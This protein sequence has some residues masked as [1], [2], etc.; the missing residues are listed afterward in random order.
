MIRYQRQSFSVWL[1]EVLCLGLVYLLT[2]SSGIAQTTQLAVGQ[3]LERELAGGQSH[4]YQLTLEGG[5]FF[6]G[7]V[8]QKG[9]DV[10]VSIVSPDGKTTLEV[11]SPNGA[12]GTESFSVVSA[13]AGSYQIIVRAIEKGALPGRYEIKLTDLRAASKDEAALFAGQQIYADAQ[14]LGAKRTAIPMREAQ[15][16]YR[17]ALELFQAV[18][19]H[20][21]QAQSYREIGLLWRLLGDHEQALEAYRQALP[22]FRAAGNKTAEAR[23]LNNLG[24]TYSDLGNPT[25]AVSHL[26]QAIQQLRALND[27]VEVGVAW[28]NLGKVYRRFSNFPR[29]LECHTA[30]LEIFQKLKRPASET[31]TLGNLGSLYNLLGDRERAV[32]FHQQALALSRTHKNQQA[33]AFNLNS[34]GGLYR[35]LDQPEQ[36]RHFTEQGLALNRKVGNKNG[37]ATALVYLG[38]L[39]FAQGEREAGLELMAQGVTIGRNLKNSISIAI[40]LGDLGYFL[41]EAGRSDEAIPHLL[42]SLTLARQTGQS[43]NERLALHYLAL[44]ER[45]RGRFTEARAYLDQSIAIVER[46]RQDVYSLPQRAAIVSSKQGFYSDS[47]DLY[48]RQHQQAPQSGFDALALAGNEQALA[49]SLLD[50]LSESRLELRMGVDSSLLA[51]EGQLQLAFSNKAA[52]RDR[53]KNDQA[54]T[55]RL[56]ELTQQL[57]ALNAEIETTQAT[58]RR[59]SPRF[60]ALVQT[61]PASLKEIQ[62]LLDADTL[63]LEYALG[64]RRSHLLVV[65]ANELQSY[66]LPKYGAIAAAARQAYRELTNAPAPV[67]PGSSKTLAALSQLLLSPIRAKLQREWKGKRLLVVA[68]YELQ[69]IPFA[70]LPIDTDHQIPLLTN[71]EIINLPSASVLAVLRKQ[72]AGRAVA[73]L[74]VAVL[75]DPVFSESDARVKS[76]LAKQSGAVSKEPEKDASLTASLQRAVRSVTGEDRAGLQRL[77]FTRYEAEAIAAL[78]PAGSVLKALDFQASRATA[79]SDKLANYRIIHFATHGLLDSAHPELSG[80]ALSLVDENGKPQDGYLRLNEIFNLK[81]NAD[82][83]VLSACQTGLGKEV[84]GE[85]LIGLT[86]GFMYAGAP[87]VVASL[88]QVNDAAT[89]ELMK[90]FY[91]GM[92][93]EKLRPAAALRQAQLELMKKPAW[94]APYYWGAFVLQG[95]WK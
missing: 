70:T 16:K 27:E 9:I 23:M 95:E 56:A 17:Q 77:A 11:D 12:Q 87:R 76:A 67:T 59:A 91:R 58:I 44:A 69:Y 79:L 31:I 2:V 35:L 75:G 38:K 18:D 65:T 20:Q 63:L 26:E 64:S 37:E 7:I 39:L 48:L 6:R 28:D 25:E 46:N 49:R 71:H 33:E 42:E 72:F 50:L 53:L 43:S 14:T 51:R 80:L 22:L 34:L 52:L 41:N 15:A 61:Q 83:V 8:E 74:T 78:V 84:K 30:A 92:L 62:S 5:Q 68:P 85:G 4:A 45:D 32:Q 54:A 21:W 55:T 88:W 40:S 73:P 81:L 1:C 60:S 57:A 89:A 90:R 13:L 10:A 19:D 93:K 29:A 3:P 82:L 66:E 86:R 47:V 24:D 36:A 94:S